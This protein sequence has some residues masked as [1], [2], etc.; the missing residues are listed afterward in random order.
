M[1]K[2][3]GATEWT[4]HEVLEVIEKGSMTWQ[5]QVT[6]IYYFCTFLTPPYL[7]IPTAIYI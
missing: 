7:E 6:P 2:S 3:S 5:T 4:T 1:L